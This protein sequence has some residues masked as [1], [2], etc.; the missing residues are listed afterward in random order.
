MRFREIVEGDASGIIEPVA[1]DLRPE[2]DRYQTS[3]PRPKKRLRWQ[4]PE[5]SPPPVAAKPPTSSA[6]STRPRPAAPKPPTPATPPAQ[7]GGRG[8]DQ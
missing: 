8:Q 5:T 4:T 1:P 6:G 7:G 3:Q 2:A